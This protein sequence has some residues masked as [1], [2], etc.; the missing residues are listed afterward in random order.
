MPPAPPCPCCSGLRYRE[1]CAPFHRGE[2]EAPDAERLMRSRYA[3]FAQ[4]EA[5]YLWKTLHPDHPDRARPQEEVLRELRDFAR[6]HQYPKLV[7]MDRRPP[8]ANGVAQ[9]LFFAKV[10]EKGKERS[11]VERSYFRHDG[12]GWR[13]HSGDTRM[14]RDLPVPPEALTLDTFPE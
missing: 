14:P 3:A 6:A 2:A 8:D 10:F 7:V 9:V 12:T 1:C 4:R 13:Y 5:A 11:F